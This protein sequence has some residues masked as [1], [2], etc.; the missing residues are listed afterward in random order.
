MMQ[1][2]DSV[3]GGLWRICDAVLARGLWYGTVAVLLLLLARVLL[4]RVPRRAAA[5]LWVCLPVI[6]L[7]P[8]WPRV[9]VEADTLWNTF[10]PKDAVIQTE[11]TERDAGIT[12]TGVLTVTQT[13][14]A[15]IPLSPSAGNEADEN[16]EV[17]VSYSLTQEAAVT[18]AWAVGVLGMGIWTLMEG[19]SVRRMC[20]GAALLT[21]R[22]NVRIFRA[23]G[24]GEPFA[25]GI[26]RPAVYLPMSM[27]EDSAETEAVLAHE[28]AH[29][30]RGDILLRRA[31]RLCLCIYWFQP[32]LWF[33][34]RYFLSDT[35]G[36]CDEMALAALLDGNRSGIPGDADERE[37]R[38]TYAETL[39][40]YAGRKKSGV[41]SFGAAGRGMKQRV[42]NVLAPNPMRAGGIA[43][44]VIAGLLLCACMAVEPTV[45]GTDTDETQERG[46]DTAVSDSTEQD[47]S[48]TMSPET[49]TPDATQP[50]DSTVTLTV[51]P[52]AERFGFVETYFEKYAQ[53]YWDAPVSVS[54]SLPEIWSVSED[55]GA[56]YDENGTVVASVSVV[57]FDPLDDDPPENVPGAGSE[58]M[59]IYTDMR[60]STM[61]NIAD[62]DYRVIARGDRWENAVAILHYS[63]PEENVPAAAWE[64]KT[65]PIILAYNM[66]CSM[67]LK[68][69]FEDVGISDEIQEK[70]AGSAVF[71]K[72][73]QDLGTQVAYN[74]VT[75]TQTPTAELLICN[76]AYFQENVDMGYWDTPF[77]V[78]FDI[79]D[80]WTAELNAEGELAT[81]LCEEAL[82]GNI[83]FRNGKLFDGDGKQI[84]YFGVN[85]FDRLDDD[86][87]EN[88]PPAGDEWQ[89]IYVNLRLSAN[90][91]VSNDDY[92][93]VARGDRYENAVAILH[94]S[95]PEENVPAAAWEQKTAP[96]ILAYNMDCSMYLQINFT[97]DSV[98]DDVR[99]RIAGCV[100][101]EKIYENTATPQNP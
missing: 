17:E 54:F 45:G 94:Y 55:G 28:L 19:R 57:P 83:G 58:W 90:Q 42:E 77:S 39:L 86:P 66:D 96:I 64:Q 85:C 78:S 49:M 43:G 29:H 63:V 41:L 15:D 60:L 95:V 3:I 69:V 74:T 92:H 40:R 22:G 11:E 100:V 76:E 99:E 59:A 68:I 82:I 81:G 53:I 48:Q 51:I 24:V 73:S 61:Q 88:V 6:L 52:T 2:L 16:V 89:A 98:A 8:A 7:L 30:R 101:F 47:P 36:A 34:G 31:W 79:P 93:A 33:A 70:I 37:L 67:Y 1:V 10:F 38:A 26:F 32:L 72:V 87:P 27:Q 13:P 5:W 9:T 84:A 25:R 4:R 14:A 44:I 46:A 62:D 97:D 80:G 91:Q 56:L 65:A 75:L 20:R 23:P 50:A 71:E 18:L 35:E 21:T 12:D